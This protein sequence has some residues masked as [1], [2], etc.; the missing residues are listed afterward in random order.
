MDR[1]VGESLRVRS[2]T[3]VGDKFPKLSSIKKNGFNGIEVDGYGF[4]FLPPK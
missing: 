2:E 4:T 3:G 1:T